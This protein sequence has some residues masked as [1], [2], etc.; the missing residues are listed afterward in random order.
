MDN[1]LRCEYL[2]FRQ[3]SKKWGTRNEINRYALAQYMTTY[4]DT[5]NPK[6][7]WLLL[8]KDLF[9]GTRGQAYDVQQELLKPKAWRFLSI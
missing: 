6:A 2:F 9:E 1:P 3:E 8:K 4:G 7:H 5:P